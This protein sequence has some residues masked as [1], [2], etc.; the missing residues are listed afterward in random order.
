M[1]GSV[2]QPRTDY[3]AWP[4][5][6]AAVYLMLVLTVANV[7]SYVD[8]IILNLMIGPIKQSFQISD[9]QVSLLQGLAFGVFYTLAAL[10]IG[11]L[12]DFW[13]RRLIISLGGAVFSA[14]T[15]ACGLAQSYVQLFLAR[16]GVGAGE[17][18]L[19]P[20]AYSLMADTYPKEKLSGAM[21]VYTMGAFVG[22]GLAYVFGGLVVQW[23]LRTGTLD[24]PLLG[25][26][27]PWQTAFIAAGAPGLLV[28]LW[29]LTLKEP[30]RKGVAGAP[31]AKL[32]PLPMREVLGHLA[33]RAG[34]Y[35]PLFG[36]FCLITLS[37]YA[38]TSW[39]P[40]FLGRVHGMDAGQTGLT[41]GLVVL[42][43]GTTGALAGGRLADWL[44]R[45]GRPDAPVIAAMIG[46]G[47]AWLPGLIAPLAPTR[48]TTI[49]A[50]AVRE[51]FAVFPF[52]LA[53]AAI[54]MVTP[55]QLRGQTTAVYFFA[56]NLVGLGLGPTVTALLSDHVFTET[57]GVRYSL[58][59]VSGVAAPLALILLALARAPYRRA[60]AESN[61]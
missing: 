26:V 45:R 54:Q 33:G 10:P 34:L 3:D 47:L 2:P 28:A 61:A 20:A 15:I 52:P 1:T 16:V 37:A 46:V 39:T 36:G 11:R 24:L 56:I 41:L 60:A 58:A 53:A 5:Q 13:D 18:S 6:R 55:N 32:K 7:F 27:E 50:L 42:L 19:G 9:T 40:A 48:E 17:A 25:A 8:R 22:I 4:S 30:V 59:W 12:V 29:V 57:E 49:V 23:A 44:A 35:V 21:G 14:A 51:F 31:G 43:F 38:N